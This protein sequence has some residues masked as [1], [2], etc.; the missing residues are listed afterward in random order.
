[1]IIFFFHF[2]FSVKISMISYKSDNHNTMFVLFVL[3]EAFIGNESRVRVCMCVSI[4]IPW[5]VYGMKYK[6]Q[7]IT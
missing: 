5:S 3:R 1:M 6:Q 4:W 7:Y 2:N